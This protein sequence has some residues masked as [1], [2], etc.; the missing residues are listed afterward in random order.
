MVRGLLR[1]CAASHASLVLVGAVAFALASFSTTAATEDQDILVDVRTDGPAV[2]V[3]VDCP[4]AASRE[5][6]WEVLTDYDHMASFVANLETSRILSRDNDRLRIYQ[7][8]KASRG[9]LSITFENVRDI[10]L[11]PKREV[12]SRLV[13]GDL[14]E[15]E[16]TTTIVESDGVVHIRNSGRF[17]PHIWVPPLIGPSIIAAETRKQF[18]E[19]RAEILRRKSPVRPEAGDGMPATR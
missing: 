11:V 2:H 18:G 16:F 3:A 13:S 19:I 1:A 17:I 12:H 5:L 4:V 7:K 10:D 6:V 14:K 8:G 9:L 15:S